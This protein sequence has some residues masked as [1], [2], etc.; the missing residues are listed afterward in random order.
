MRFCCSWQVKVVHGH[1]KLSQPECLVVI[2]SLKIIF[3][4]VQSM[5]KSFLLQQQRGGSTFLQLSNADHHKI[6]VL[7][8]ASSRSITS[9]VIVIQ[10]WVS[11]PFLSEII[12]LGGRKCL[13][14]CF[15][16][17]KVA[18]GTKKQSTLRKYV[19]LIMKWILKWPEEKKKY[20]FCLK[21]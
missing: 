2:C 13:L 5:E 7:L 1:M 17:A 16:L 21:M 20:H 12:K 3:F 4:L 11:L 10:V 18:C 15:L 6:H 19:A 8:L 14:D 9:N